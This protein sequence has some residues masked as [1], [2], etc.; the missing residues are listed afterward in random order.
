MMATQAAFKSDGSDVEDVQ[1][2]ANS[3]TL[4]GKEKSELLQ[5]ALNMAA[6]NGEH[7]RVRKL[8]TEEPSSKLVDVNM[9][10]EEGTSALIYASCFV[11][12]LSPR[13]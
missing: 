2:I 4:S 6:S 9:L 13:S 10:D 8:L 1:E 3:S 7:K 11:R 5:K 12:E